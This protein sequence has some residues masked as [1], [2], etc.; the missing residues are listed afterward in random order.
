LQN[1]YKKGA[2]QIGKSHL[3]VS[4]LHHILGLGRDLGAL[5][6]YYG[7]VRNSLFFWF[8]CQTHR[9]ETMT[10]VTVDPYTEVDFDVIIETCIPLSFAVNSNR[11][12]GVPDVYPFIVTKDMIK[13]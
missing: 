12:M 3:L 4:M 2:P 11:A 13:K 10:N 6:A 1:Y 8:E 5:S 9:Y 7:Y